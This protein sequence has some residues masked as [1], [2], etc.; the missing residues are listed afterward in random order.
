MA[1]PQLTSSQQVLAALQASYGSALWNQWQVHRF[2]KYDYIRYPAAGATSLTF[3]AN[4]L[5]T[6]DPVS[7]LQKTVEETNLPKSRSFGQVYYLITQIRTDVRWLAKSR[8]ATGISDDAD[9]IYTTMTNAMSAFRNI[10]NRGVLNISFAQKRFFQI[11]QPFVTCP[12]GYGIEIFNHS[13]SYIAAASAYTQFS[14]W[15]ETSSRRDN[16]YDLVPQQLVEPEV[17][18]DITVD[19]PDGTS[20]ALTTLV[21]GVSPRL[22]VGV[23]FDGYEIRPAQ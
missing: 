11:S 23:I 19:F 20:P 22:E 5:G 9:V 13:S 7:T 10:L 12:P 14:L 18:I 17:T 21:N 6:V 1:Q 16:I 15:N 4:P 2:P 8:Q 3:M